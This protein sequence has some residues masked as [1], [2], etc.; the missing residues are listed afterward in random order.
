MKKKEQNKSKN[1][2]ETKTHWWSLIDADAISESIGFYGGKLD[3]DT[4]FD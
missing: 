3:D 1:E 2:R 4:Y